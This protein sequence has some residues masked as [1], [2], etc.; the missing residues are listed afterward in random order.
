MRG[1][2]GKN[3]LIT[4]GTSGIGEAAARRF[5][6]EGARVFVCGLDG[7]DETVAG[8]SGLGEISGTVCDVSREDDVARLVARAR[9]AL[10]GVDVLINNAGT[11][12][13]EPFLEITPAHWDTII[14]VNLRGMF[15]VGQAVGRV[16]VESG[17]GGAIVNMA[18]TNAL[19]GEEDYAHYNASKG[20][21]LL[22]TKTMAVEL[23]RHGVRV[24]AVCP[25]YIRTPLNASIEA[26]LDPDFVAAYQRDHI[27]L[28]RAGQAA[29]VASAY[30]FLASDDASFV[31][32]AELVI[33][34][35]QLAIM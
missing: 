31:H 23:G 17:A 9:S 19:G 28:G 33:D 10:G 27:P 15:L 32:G 1:L 26:T 21:V 8:L 13:R 30:A 7:V 24:N 6:E 4:G 29:E 5:L 18:S 11:S 2:T 34:G 35:G 20:G 3:V 12:W 16:M 25:G 22:L 14:A